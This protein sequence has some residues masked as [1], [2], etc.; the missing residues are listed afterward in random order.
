[1]EFKGEMKEFS[2]LQVLSKFVA[3]YEQAKQELKIGP[4]EMVPV[5]EKI[6]WSL[7][8]HVSRAKLDEFVRMLSV[9]LN[10]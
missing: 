6:N 7:P 9:Y 2:T 4:D 1:M 8:P 3:G 10:T 5:E